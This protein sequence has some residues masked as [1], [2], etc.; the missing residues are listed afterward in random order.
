MDLK[1]LTAEEL[2]EFQCRNP[3]WYEILTE[4]EQETE[5]ASHKLDSHHIVNS[6]QQT[7][8]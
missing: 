2:Y 7:D 6:E 4:L 3:G 5:P 1:H 8:R